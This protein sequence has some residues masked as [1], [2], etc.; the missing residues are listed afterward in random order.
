M[1]REV[2]IQ[3]IYETMGLMKRRMSASL[4]PMFEKLGISLAQI[5]LL[6]TIEHEQPISPKALAAKLQLTPG[7][8]SQM[9]AALQ[10]SNSIT[11]TH[12]QS[13]RRVSSVR[14][15]DHGK[16]WLEELRTMRFQHLTTAFEQLSDT[17]LEQYLHIQQKLLQFYEQSYTTATK[18]KKET[19]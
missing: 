10:N 2:I 6:F 15:S 9:L 1:D 8:V 5:D 18:Q 13:D 17:E 12:E 16:K 19:L 14:L 4:Q 3:Q 7:A 11:L